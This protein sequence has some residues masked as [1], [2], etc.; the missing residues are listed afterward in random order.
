MGSFLRVDRSAMS[1]ISA[2]DVVDIRFP[3]AGDR[4]V[5]YVVLRTDTELAGHGIS[6]TTSGT[7]LCVLAARRIAEPLVGRD[8]DDLAG[9]LG[10]TYRQIVGDDRWRWTGPQWGLVRL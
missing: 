7:A 1:K 6:F 3:P 8:V 4:C 10:E 5:V 2:V 9:S